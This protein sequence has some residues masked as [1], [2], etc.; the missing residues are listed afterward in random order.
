M[1]YN[2]Y[3]WLTENGNMYGCGCNR[4][5][6]LNIGSPD[7]SGDQGWTGSAR[8]FARIPAM[9]DATADGNFVSDTGNSGTGTANYFANIVDLINTGGGWWA[10][11]ADGHCYSTGQNTGGFLGTG[12]D[13][14]INVQG[15]RVRAGGSASYGAPLQYY[16][17]PGDGNRYLKWDAAMNPNTILNT[18]TYCCYGVF[19]GNDVLLW[20]DNSSQQLAVYDGVTNIFFGLTARANDYLPRVYMNIEDIENSITYLDAATLDPSG[21]PYQFDTRIFNNG[22]YRMEIVTPPFTVFEKEIPIDTIG[23]NDFSC[24]LFTTLG[25]DVRTADLHFTPYFNDNEIAAVAAANSYTA[26]LTPDRLIYRPGDAG[27][28]CTGPRRRQR[29][30]RHRAPPGT[31]RRRRTGRQRQLCGDRGR[32]IPFEN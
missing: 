11:A 22:L 23:R 32:E 17:E 30:P 20:G 18:H 8:Y 31:R 4:W 7:N 13:V 16:F 21:A 25:D 12:D 26:I 29:D 3:I 15:K 5:G 2:V 19:I 6:M 14:T 28:R 1:S 9:A 27:Q 24:S 10:I